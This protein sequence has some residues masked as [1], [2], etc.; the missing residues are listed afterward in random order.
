VNIPERGNGSLWRKGVR[1]GFLIKKT[2]HR[3]ESVFSEMF[4]VAGG[5][6]GGKEGAR[7]NKEHQ[8]PKDSLYPYSR[9]CVATGGPTIKSSS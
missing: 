6:G 1:E 8:P 4:K 2:F 9:H 7:E 3:G 5:G